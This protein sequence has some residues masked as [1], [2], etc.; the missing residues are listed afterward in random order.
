MSQDELPITP[1]RRFYDALLALYEQEQT[2]LAELDAQ[3]PR[4]LIHRFRESVKALG[5]RR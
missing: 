3:D 4:L 2:A 1:L 5:K